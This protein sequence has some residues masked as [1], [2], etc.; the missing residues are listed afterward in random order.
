MKIKKYFATDMRQ[1]IEMAK[2]ENGPDVVILSNRKVLGGVELIVADDYDEAYFKQNDKQTQQA[3]ASADII[4]AEVVQETAVTPDTPRK[5][6][7]ETVTDIWTNE[8]TMDQMR[9]EIKSLRSMLEQQ[10]S[11]LAW[12]DIG[13]QHPLWANLIRQL[14]NLEIAP[15]LARRIVEEIPEHY[16]FDQAWR[17]VL[18]LLA[19]QIPQYDRQLLA[20]GN[21]VQF[22][23]PTGSGKTTSVAKLATRFALKYGTSNILLATTDNYRVGAREQLRGYARILGIP[24]RTINNRDDYLSL[25]NEVN[26]EKLILVDTAGVSFRNE[27]YQQQISLLSSAPSHTLNCLI[28]PA[29]ENFNSLSKLIDSYQSLSLDCCITTKLD[30]AASLGNVLSTAIEKN[31]SIASVC[32]GQRVPE[33]ISQPKPHDLITRMVSRAQQS[34]IQFE[35]EHL[36]QAYGNFEFQHGLRH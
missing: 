10:M 19:Y 26:R 15:S 36:E 3:K 28:L 7:N 30:E 17:T 9:F 22:V 25:F 24:V 5:S 34:N 8:S 4:D 16:A 13:R 2:E 23:G 35:E 12:G 14:I 29:T 6:L 31:L 18:A 20:A 27:Q 33:D 32:E 11:S 1:A 21:V